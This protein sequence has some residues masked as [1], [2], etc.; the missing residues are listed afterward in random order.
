MNIT[1]TLL[2]QAI[3]FAIFVLFCMKFVW[4]PIIGALRERQKNIS[5]GLQAAEK[6]HLDLAQ[7]EKK[8]AEI[9]QEGKNQASVII[10]NANKRAATIV[11]EAKHQAED[12]KERILN[13]ADQEIKQNTE[14]A[15]GELRTSLSSLISQ[16]VNKIIGKEVDISTHQSII[17]QLD[18][19]MK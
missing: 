9:V 11:E 13:T 18:S 10:A 17:S 19:E 8:S 4:P 5:D 12:E 3:S 16:G 2:G 6:A 7:A 14:R 15:R 1:L